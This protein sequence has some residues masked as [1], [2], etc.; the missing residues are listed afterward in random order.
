MSFST[1]YLFPLKLNKMI[2]LQAAPKFGLSSNGPFLT[3]FD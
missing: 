2:T 3:F 1:K